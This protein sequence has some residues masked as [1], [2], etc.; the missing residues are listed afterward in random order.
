MLISR[1]IAPRTSRVEESPTPEPGAGQ[2]LIE[3]LAS[4][5]CTSDFGPWMRGPEGGSPIELGHETAGRV[6]ATGSTTSR[7]AVGDLVTG[8][9]GPGFAT[10]TLLDE[11]AA[12]PLPA[13]LA[14]SHAIGEPIATLEEA[15]SRTPIG[16][17][18]RVAVV[19][20]GFMGLGLVQL[21]K[22]RAPH[23]IIGVDPNPAA[24][25]R[26]L[27]WGADVALH[28]DEVPGFT[29]SSSDAGATDPRADVVLEATGVTPGLDT[30]SP[31]VRPFGTLCIV[32]YHHAGTAKLDMELW[33]KG[34]TVVNGFCPDRPRVMHAMQDALDLVAS[35]RFSYSPLV[36]HTMGLDGVD[37]AYAL[38][39]ARDPSF[40]KA[41]VVP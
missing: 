30:A 15:I 13:G 33:Y 3:V 24:R 35:H 18:S 21:A 1:V 34:A 2:I 19:G 12:L 25:R 40:V 4:G 38:M 23:T 32:G 26:A 37:G 16:A 27:E 17:G 41:V 7:W 10:H 28:P 36:T 6:V 9:G 11:N 22:A 31:L 39:E 29:A 20:L 5:V 14:P 8:L